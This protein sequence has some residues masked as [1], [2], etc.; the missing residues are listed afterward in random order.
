MVDFAR[1]RARE[2]AK[3]EGTIGGAIARFHA[4]LSPSKAHRFLVCPGSMHFNGEDPETEWAAEGTR[5]HAVLERV[6]SDRKMEAIQDQQ[7]LVPDAPLMA[8]E[9]IDTPAGKYKVPLAVLEQCFEIADFI[10]SFRATHST[11]V[12]ETETRVEIGTHVWPKVLKKDDCSGTVD[13]TAWTDDELLV[14]DAKFGFIQVEARGNPQLMLY[15]A[16]LLAEIPFPIKWVTLCIAQPGYDG[17]V[18]FREHRLLADDVVAWA[19]DQMHVVEEIQSGS[20]RLQADDHACRY[21][22]AR[23]SCPARMQAL[24]AVRFENFMVEPNLEELLPLLPRIRQTCADLEALA[25]RRINEGTPVR[26]FKLVESSSKRK[27]VMGTDGEPDAQAVL[28]TICVLDNMDTEEF[29]ESKL[30]SPAK[31]S[32]LLRKKANEQKPKSLTVKEADEWVAQVALK[33]RGQPK[34]VPESDERPAL[35]KVTWSQEDILA[36]QLEAS[37]FEE[38]GE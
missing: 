20:K 28:N 3:D 34:L 25:V 15:A 29:Y 11:W 26:G 27:W 12:V 19:F 14:L 37:T 8:G 7:H 18:I 23:T 5:K 16:G 21:C 36:G 6:L 17:I 1:L 24:E 22:P 33:P 2:Q 9:E 4:R 10:D 31:A 30:I 32:K 13:A 38:E 35:A